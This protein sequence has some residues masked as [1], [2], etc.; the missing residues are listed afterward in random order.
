MAKLVA[1]LD[2][3]ALG[4]IVH[5]VFALHG[6]RGGDLLDL[7]QENHILIAAHAERYLVFA[8]TYDNPDLRL[9]H[10]RKT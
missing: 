4:I 10:I 1:F 9:S 3:K 5:A 6:L 8:A 7:C 2:T